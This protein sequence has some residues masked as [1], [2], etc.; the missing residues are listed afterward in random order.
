MKGRTR[1][2]IRGRLKSADSL[3]ES[4]PTAVDTCNSN[5]TVASHCGD[6]A[7]AT[8]TRDDDIT[9]RRGVSHIRTRQDALNSHKD[10]KRPQAEATVAS[11]AL[12]RNATDNAVMANLSVCV[13]MSPKLNGQLSDPSHLGDSSV[14]TTRSVTRRLSLAGQDAE[15]VASRLTV[16]RQ[17]STPPLNSSAV[18][19]PRQRTC[20]RFHMIAQPIVLADSTENDSSY[21]SSYSMLSDSELSKCNSPDSQNGGSLF[22]G[23]LLFGL[24]GRG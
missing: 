14:V 15:S 9:D 18:Q 12:G 2:C 3:L 4:S 1:N 23:E 21:E 11:P 17:L 6:N 10:S 20:G 22:T 24:F 19:S 5:A 16:K 8:V 7:V 13:S